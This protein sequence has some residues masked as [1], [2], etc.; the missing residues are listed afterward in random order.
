VLVERKVPTASTVEAGITELPANVDAVGTKSVIAQLDEVLPNDVI[1]DVGPRTTALLM[2]EARRSA[3]IV[4]NG[5]LGWYEKGYTNGSRTFAMSISQSNAV[6]IIGGGDTVSAI[7]T[8]DFRVEGHCTFVSAGGG[9][10]LDFMMD[11]ELVALK[12]L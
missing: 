9:A 6:S 10:M 3:Y 5:P 12:E 4:W 8:P 2:E 11:G 7:E 1:V